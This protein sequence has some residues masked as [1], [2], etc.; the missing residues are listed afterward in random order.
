MEK[1]KQKRLA[2]LTTF[3]EQHP[4]NSFKGSTSGEDEGWRHLVIHPVG[5]PE[6]IGCHSTRGWKNA[7]LMPTIIAQCRRETGPQGKTISRAL[8][9]ALGTEG[10]EERSHFYL[11]QVKRERRMWEGGEM[12]IWKRNDIWSE[13]EKQRILR[14]LKGKNFM[15]RE[16][17]G[18]SRIAVTSSRTR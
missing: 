4:T 10:T 17:R 9:A 18:C 11:N 3:Q 7:C 1:N 8:V 16:R 13:C 15:E 6:F 2:H 5:F 12:F 14:R